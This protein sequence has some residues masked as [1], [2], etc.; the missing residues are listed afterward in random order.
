MI[1]YKITLITIVK[2]N[3]FISGKKILNR[4]FTSSSSYKVQDQYSDTLRV[5]NQTVENLIN[6]TYQEILVYLSKNTAS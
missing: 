1:K 5:E 6:K 2:I 4:N 3:D